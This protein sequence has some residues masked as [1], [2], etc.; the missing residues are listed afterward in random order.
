MKCSSSFT[1]KLNNSALKKI[2]K[3]AKIAL[4]ETAEA[5][6]TEVVNAQVVPFDVGTMQESMDVDR[7]KIN[8][9]LATIT[10]NTPYARR[11]Y[12]HPE[13]N[14][15]KTNNPNAKGKWFEDWMPDGKYGN[16]AK[17]EFA[18]LYKKYAGGVIK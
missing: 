13:Y 15:Q 9:G 4:G 1:L 6:K 7:S 12:F 14:F 10:V 16:F 8:N 11:M 3:G 5:V 18:K 2:T 17:Q